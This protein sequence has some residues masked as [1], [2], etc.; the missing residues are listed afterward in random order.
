LLPSRDLKTGEFLDTYT[1]R[2]YLAHPID[3]RYDLASRGEDVNIKV[4]Q[5][6]IHGVTSIPAEYYISAFE[7]GKT[8]EAMERLKDTT[9]SLTCSFHHPHPPYLGAKSYVDQFPAADMPVPESINDDMS[10][11]PYLRS[12]KSTSQMYSDP[13]KV[14]YFTSE[15]YAMVKEVDDW[16]GK[17]LDKLD[18]LGLAENTLVVFTSDHG[19]MLGAHG[20]RG[21]FNFY[22][23]SSHIPLMIRFPGRIKPGTVVNNYVS[24]VDLFATILDYMNMPEKPSDGYSLRGLIEGTDKENG[25]YVVTEWL[26]DLKTKPSHMVIKDGWKLML[27]DSSAKNVIKALYD[28]NTDPNEMNNLLGSNMDENIYRSKVVELETCF[29]E[30]TERGRIINLN[31]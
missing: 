19:E 29:K 23:E 24:T 18:E 20:L 10:T 4:G 13:E 28:L 5:S 16:V 11:S 27:P 25:K 30:W 22:E 26:S 7:G 6:D 3:R 9:F 14:Q 15:Y 1:E 8:L 31:K 17:I 2:P 12:K 21:K